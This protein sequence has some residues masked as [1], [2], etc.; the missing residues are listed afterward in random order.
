MAKFRGKGDFPPQISKNILT[1]IARDSEAVKPLAHLP[2]VWER[3][4]G[5]VILRQCFPHCPHS[6][7]PPGPLALSAVLK[8]GAWR[9]G[10]LAWKQL[11]EGRG[12]RARSL[13]GI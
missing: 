1:M 10:G 7:W 13:H 6:G 5:G 2:S 11:W 8:P 9:S 12:D 4:E 3:E